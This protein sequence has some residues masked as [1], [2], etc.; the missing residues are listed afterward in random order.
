MTINMQGALE[1]FETLKPASKAK[2]EVYA[3]RCY[4]DFTNPEVAMAWVKNRGDKDW[5]RALT[6]PWY[7]LV[8]SC[9]TPTGLI[10]QGAYDPDS[11]IQSDRGTTRTPGLRRTVHQVIKKGASLPPFLYSVVLGEPSRAGDFNLAVELIAEGTR[12]SMINNENIS[13]IT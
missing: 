3:Q 7:D 2:I 9:S 6:R 11:R 8:H 4:L 10:T 12:Q 13:T 5:E 1:R